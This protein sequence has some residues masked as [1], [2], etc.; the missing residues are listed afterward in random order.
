LTK[1]FSSMALSALFTAEFPELEAALSQ[2]PFPPEGIHLA[3]GTAGFRTKAELLDSTFLRCVPC[4]CALPDSPPLPHPP[5]NDRYIAGSLYQ[6]CC[7][8][9]EKNSM[10]A[11]AALRSRFHGGAA[12]GLMVTASHNAEPDNGRTIARAL[13]LRG[14][15]LALHHL[16]SLPFSFSQTG[17]KMVDA[18][19]GMLA[20]SWE[21]LAQVVHV[22]AGERR[23]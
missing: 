3:Y 10:G 14:Q 8:H 4:G 21:A 18:N 16:S 23:W 1:A 7:C 2:P 17:I 9:N 12:V 15:R 5:L 20:Q 11:L 22:D 6:Y 13:F 19:G